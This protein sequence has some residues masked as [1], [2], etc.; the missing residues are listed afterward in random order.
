MDSRAFIHFHSFDRAVSVPFNLEYRLVIDGL[1]TDD[2]LLARQSP[3]NR[4]SIHSD[5]F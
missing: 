1:L 3:F 4:V 2:A 5:H